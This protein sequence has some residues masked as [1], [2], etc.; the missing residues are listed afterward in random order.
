MYITSFSNL[1]GLSGLLETWIALDKLCREIY[2]LVVVIEFQTSPN[3][4]VVVYEKAATQSSC[5]APEMLCGL[6]NNSTFHQH[7][8]HF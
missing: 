5:E 1:F 3:V 2:F 8:G 7:G 6:Q 4:L